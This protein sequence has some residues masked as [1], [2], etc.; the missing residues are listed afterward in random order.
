MYISN[1]ALSMASVICLAC[2]LASKLWQST[3][4]SSQTFFSYAWGLL[5]LHILLSLILMD[6]AY[7]KHF[8]I[9][10]RLNVLGQISLLSGTLAFFA[11]L[12]IKSRSSTEK[13]V[14]QTVRVRSGLTSWTLMIIVGTAVHLIAMGAFQFSERVYPGSWFAN[15]HWPVGLPPISLIAFCVF[16]L[17]V[18]V[19]LLAGL[20]KL[21]SAKILQLQGEKSSP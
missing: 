15:N 6:P 10:N 13:S 21:I 20:I 8:Y 12:Q 3:K 7:Y 16:V 1:K 2:A 4:D 14:Q 19:W 9:F 5:C 11:W 18:L 17:S